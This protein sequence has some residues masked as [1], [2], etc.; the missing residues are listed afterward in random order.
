M[1]VDCMN[2]DTDDGHPSLLYAGDVA[3][4]FRMADKD[5]YKRA[6]RE[7]IRASD[8]DFRQIAHAGL[9]AYMRGLF[10]EWFAYD[11]PV[12][13]SGT[14]PFD[15]I[16]GAMF[17]LDG[18]VGERQYRDFREFSS[19]TFAAWFWI[20]DANASTRIMSVENLADGRRYEVYA[21]DFAARCDGAK[22]GSMLVRIARPRGTWRMLGNPNVYLREPNDEDEHHYLSSIIRGWNPGFPELVGTLFAPHPGLVR[23]DG[24]RIV[25]RAAPEGLRAVAVEPC[26]GHDGRGVP[27]MSG[28]SGLS[29]LPGLPGED[30]DPP[31]RRKRPKR[32]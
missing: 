29:G 13:E 10:E 4:L 5:E 8:I 22:G 12:D 28:L 20:L 16:A 18:T 9:R 23:K 25:G 30:D 32:R 26:A 19:T 15:I 24:T 7:F 21:G 3:R 14:T 31:P 2:D 11:R 1:T 6:R 17:E 27:G